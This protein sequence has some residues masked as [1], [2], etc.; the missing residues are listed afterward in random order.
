MAPVPPSP[1]INALANGGN[2]EL[3]SASVGAVAIAPP[4]AAIEKAGSRIIRSSPTERGM[5]SSEVQSPTENIDDDIGQIADATEV[6]VNFIGAVLPLPSSSYFANSEI[7]LAEEHV[8][9]YRSRLIKLVYDFLPY[10]PR[11][12]DYGPNYPV[13]YKLHVTRDPSCDEPL[14]QMTSSVTTSGSTPINRLQLDPKYSNQQQST[15]A[16]FRT[17]ADDYRK[18]TR[19]RQ[20]K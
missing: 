16:C 13:V 12:S 17:T 11:L 6:S 5:R 15:L 19:R 8:N 4:P 2:R 3:S 18:A 9:R 7:F 1:T 10:Q 14:M 20:H